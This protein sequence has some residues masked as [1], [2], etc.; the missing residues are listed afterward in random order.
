MRAS[1]VPSSLSK[2]HT[3]RLDVRE[4]VVIDYLA[5]SLYQVKTLNIRYDTGQWREVTD[6]RIHF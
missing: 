6:A 5:N 3:D 2:K 4:E 1:S